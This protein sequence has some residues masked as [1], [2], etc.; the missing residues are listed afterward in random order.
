LPGCIAGLLAGQYN[1]GSTL[2]LARRRGFQ[3]VTATSPTNAAGCPSQDAGRMAYDEPL[4]SRGWTPFL[5]PVRR[6]A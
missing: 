6:K 2:C 4:A 5:P 3:V 1:H